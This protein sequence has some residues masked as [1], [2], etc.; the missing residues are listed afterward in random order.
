M[1]QYQYGITA[2][3]ALLS[4]LPKLL[5]KNILLHYITVHNDGM[6]RHVKCNSLESV[7]LLLMFLAQ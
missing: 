6:L 1:Q 7:M 3:G 2:A 5:Y 4:I